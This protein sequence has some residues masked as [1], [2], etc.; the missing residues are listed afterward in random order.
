VRGDAGALRPG[1]VHLLKLE[2]ATA[3][4]PAGDAFA[5]DRRPRYEALRTDRANWPPRIVVVVSG[6]AGT[7]HRIT[8]EEE[9][10]I[11]GRAPDADVRL[12]DR[13]I[14]PRQLRLRVSGDEIEIAPLPSARATRLNGKPL[15]APA[16]VT[17]QDRIDLGAPTPAPP[18]RGQPAGSV[19][20][21]A[22]S[23]PR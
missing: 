4:A 1:D 18:R 2:E 7:N 5:A 19:V 22:R 6:G 16:R 17:F 13:T 20:A 11:V 23:L 15:R 12:D 9:S 8:F 3:S 14:A 21:P 10:V